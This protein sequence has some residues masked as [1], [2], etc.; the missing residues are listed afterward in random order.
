[1]KMH[2]FVIALFSILLNG[3]FTNS[4]AQYASFQI[5]AD[6]YKGDLNKKGGVNGAALSV[7]YTYYIEDGL[8][9][10]TQFSS[11]FFSSEYTLGNGD[12]FP[13]PVP[14]GFS[15]TLYFENR[16]AGGDV[17]LQYEIVSFGPATLYSGMGVGFM[18]FRLFDRAG[19]RLESQNQ[20]RVTGETMDGTAF[21]APLSTG[22]LLFSGS[23]AQV[24]FEQQWILTNSDYLDNIGY[25]GGRGDDRIVRRS[26]VVR[27]KF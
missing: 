17:S 7:G 2:R 14:P 1:M 10:R 9:V 21:T 25:A 16:H 20:S 11:G 12:V 19:K 5:S 18:S 27:M 23:R 6:G 8:S 24:A 3:V 13:S 26:V 15:P 22:L 4:H